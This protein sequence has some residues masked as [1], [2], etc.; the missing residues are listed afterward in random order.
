[1]QRYLVMSLSLTLAF[2]TT[3]SGG[4]S[5]IAS[6]AHS[7]DPSSAPASTPRNSSAKGLYLAH[8]KTDCAAA[9]TTAA[10]SG[11]EI[12]RLISQIGAG[13]AGAFPRLISYL[14]HMAG[15]FEASLRHARTFGRP[16]NP[17]S[18]QA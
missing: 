17:G 10:A 3:G 12:Q 7:R 2:Q 9:A 18:Y 16:P 13:Q 4:A 1:M 8:F 6:T 5:H 14:A 15:E 11:L